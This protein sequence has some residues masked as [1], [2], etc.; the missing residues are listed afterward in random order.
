MKSNHGVVWGLSGVTWLPLN[1]SDVIVDAPNPTFST[2]ISKSE[3]IKLHGRD[4]GKNWTL[5]HT[6][7]FSTISLVL[8]QDVF[9]I[10]FSLVSPASFE[11]VRAKVS[12]LTER[13]RLP[14][15]L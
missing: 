7:S 8:S 15:F 12:T 9:L 2:D 14:L 1:L 11:N 4:K 10:C 3:Q 6:H 5:T 13:A